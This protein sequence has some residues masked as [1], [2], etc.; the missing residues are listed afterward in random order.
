[1]N[2]YLHL[3]SWGYHGSSTPRAHNVAY[4]MGKFDVGSG[5]IIDGTTTLDARN[6][7][8][9]AKLSWN[10]RSPSYPAPLAHHD[11][12]IPRDRSEIRD[13]QSLPDITVLNNI[14]AE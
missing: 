7:P 5:Q 11:S 10:P 14:T 2:C 12:E 6:Q 4:Q 13:I 3:E 9:G 8:A 1:M